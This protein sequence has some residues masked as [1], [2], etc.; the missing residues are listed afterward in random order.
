MPTLY[1]ENVPADLYAALRARAQA[2]RTSIATETIALLRQHV[3]TAADLRRRKGLY[4]SFLRLQ[5]L[6]A[7]AGDTAP[8]IT[9]LLRESR[10]ELERRAE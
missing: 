4:Q 8:S 5:R 2:R 9:G 1:V 3:P 10:A 7:P 6:A